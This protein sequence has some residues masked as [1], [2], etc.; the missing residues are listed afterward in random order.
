M[1]RSQSLKTAEG[2]IS[3]KNVIG[4][5][6]EAAMAMSD[7][8]LTYNSLFRPPTIVEFSVLKN[9]IKAEI[10]Q[11]GTFFCTQFPS[12]EIFINKKVGNRKN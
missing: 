7:L 8:E 9:H 6:A 2:D 12:L 5:E 1:Q 3:S 11:V 10:P 4:K